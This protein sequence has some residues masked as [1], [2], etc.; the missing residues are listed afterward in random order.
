MRICGTEPAVCN[1]I[2]WIKKGNYNGFITDYRYHSSNL[3]GAGFVCLQSGW[4]G[5]YSPC[6]S[7]YFHNNLAVKKSIP[8]VLTKQ[9]FDIRKLYIGGKL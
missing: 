4:T 6:Y 5:S 9:Y 7:S 8:P 1:K 3:L 2:I